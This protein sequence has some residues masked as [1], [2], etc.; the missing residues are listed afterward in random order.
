M[1]LDPEAAVELDSLEIVV[2]G[3]ESDVSLAVGVLEGLT[4]DRFGVSGEAVASS[5]PLELS[6]GE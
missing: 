2:E 6:R 4:F 3:T 5:E 1:S